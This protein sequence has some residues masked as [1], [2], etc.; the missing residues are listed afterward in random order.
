MRL[1]IAGPMTGLPDYNY[2]AFKAAAVELGA[3]GYETESP[4]D[5][6]D[7]TGT[8]TYEDYMRAGFLQLLRCDGVALLDG[9]ETSKGSKR[10]RQIAGWC[11]MDVAP[12]AYWLV[13]PR[14]AGS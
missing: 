4:A 12:L 13:H 5:N 1:Y 10:E 8:Q 7:G 14:R 2:P 11:G 6:E 3:L 9:W